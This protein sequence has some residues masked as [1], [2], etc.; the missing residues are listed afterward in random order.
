MIRELLL[1]LSSSRVAY[2]LLGGLFLTL[3]MVTALPISAEESFDV[4]LVIPLSGNA[5]DYGIAIKNCIELAKKDRPEIFTNIRFRYEDAS[6]DPKLAVTAFN[7][8]A[9]LQKVELFATWGV[10][11]CKALAPLAEAHKIPLVGICIDPESAANREYVIRFMNASDEFMRT[12]AEYLHEKRLNKLGIILSESAYLEELL[13]ALRRN[14]IDGQTI[15]VIDRL[16]SSENNFR[17][18]LTKLRS[19]EFDAIGVFLGP[20]QISTFYKQARELNIT[21]PTFGTNW[22]ESISEIQASNGAMIGAVF[23][24]IEIKQT[25]FDRYKALFGNDSQLAF[26][27]PAYEF[28]IT[29]GELFNS[30]AGSISKDQIIER[31]AAIKSREGTAAGPYSY[32]NDKRVGQYFRFPVAMKRVLTD[33]FEVIH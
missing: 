21:T 18:N 20:G 9:G 22:F 17:S 12:T 3:Q 13:E 24:S 23:G 16:S 31:F 33:G 32:I 28:A 11:F 4:G 8:L 29:I 2:T 14:R 7:K 15:T 1:R 30:H 19:S 6:Y 10:S 26:G 25:F 5:A 27:A